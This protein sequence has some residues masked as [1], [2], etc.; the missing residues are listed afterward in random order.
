MGVVVN[1]SFERVRRDIARK[2]DKL[3]EF[4][5]E[6]S[7]NLYGEW[8]SKQNRIYERLSGLSESLCEEISF[9][10][11]VEVPEFSKKKD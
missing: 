9:I 7:G 5:K 4:L 2:S 11:E 6:N 1:K 8:T 10:D 3:F